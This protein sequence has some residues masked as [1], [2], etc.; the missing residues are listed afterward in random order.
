MFEPLAPLA[1]VNLSIHPRVYSFAIS[2]PH[3]EIAEVRVAVRVPFESLSMAQ[4]SCPTPLVLTTI[5]VF[6][7]AF[8]I[9][10]VVSHHAEVNSLREATLNKVWFGL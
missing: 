2:F 7:H 6:H 3:F 9:S 5:C 4:V 10:L 1:I 8:S